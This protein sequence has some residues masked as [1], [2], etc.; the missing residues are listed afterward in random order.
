MNRKERISRRDLLK[1][2]ALLAPLLGLGG[3]AARGQPAKRGLGLNVV[4][5]MTDQERTI[6]HFPADWEKQNL[7]GLTRLKKNGLTFDNAFTNACMC[8]P[9]R[10]TWLS[11]YF[12]AQHGVKYTLE[13]N[14]PAD[15]Y[16]QVELPVKLKNI[17]TVMAAAGYNV[18]YKGK[19]HCSKPAGKL[20]VPADLSKYGFQRWNPQDAGANQ[21]LDQAG[22]G[23]ADND[24]RFMRD[25]GAWEDGKE[26]ALAYLSSPAADKQPFFLIVSLVNPH[27]VLFYPATYKPAGYDDT[28]LEGKIDLPATVEEDLA[29]K[30]TA[31]RQILALLAQGLG[32]LETAQMKR[33]YLNYYGNLLKASD[34]YLV[35]VLDALEKKKLIDSTLIIRTADHGEMG[36]AHGGLRQKNFN[37]YEESLRVPLVY[38]N[39]TLFKN[40]RQSSALVS[41]VDFLPTLAN[42]F[43]APAAARADWQGI[44]YS[45]LVLDPSAPPVQDYVVFTY[46]D[47]QSGQAAPIFPPPPNR[48]VSIREERYKLAQ[49]YDVD[50]KAPSQWEMYDLK[51]DPLELANL[52]HNLDKQPKEVQQQYERLRQKLGEVQAKRLQP[53]G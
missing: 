47:Y 36:L 45:K 10:S 30:P 21:D 29:T 7:P 52:A 2:A 26:G 12:P 38:S 53:L 9:A 22:G 11:G 16:P 6:Q 24:G 18:V 15:K 33:N 37:F 23:K 40:P 41:H 14:M 4:L 39:P 13:Q 43:A 20:W 35:E 51:N 8:S 27:D 25:N 32:K 46:D 19:W 31:Q 44:D 3:G 49:Y 42:L 28:W 34:K 50:G 17:A 48:I 1:S 5:F